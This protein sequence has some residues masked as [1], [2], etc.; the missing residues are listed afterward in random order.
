[1]PMNYLDD[2]ERTIG[3]GGLRF[4]CPAGSLDEWCIAETHAELVAIA[5]KAANSRRFPTNIYRLIGK[6][7]AVIG[8]PYLVVRKILQQNSDRTPNFQWS[9][10]DTLEAA[11]MVRDVSQGLTPLFGAV[12]EQSFEPM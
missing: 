9:L 8:T 1:M 5:Q 6:T 11:E 4:A 12:I 2:L 3:T 10:V 7:E